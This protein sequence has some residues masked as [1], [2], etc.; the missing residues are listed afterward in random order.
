MTNTSDESFAIVPE[1]IPNSG[2][3]NIHILKRLAF[4]SCILPVPRPIAYGT[5]FVIT[6]MEF[7]VG[8]PLL[9]TKLREIDVSLL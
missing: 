9:K 1:V 3:N 4:S 5:V 2:K 6:Y 8:N 7:I